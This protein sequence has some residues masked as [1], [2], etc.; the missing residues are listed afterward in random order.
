MGPAGARSSAD[1]A[2][3]YPAAKIRPAVHDGQW[4]SFA[5]SGGSG[6]S[7]EGRGS[8]T[9]ARNTA[10]SEAGFRSFGS[11]NG[12]FRGGPGFAGRGYYGWGGGVW[13]G[14]G[15]GWGRGWGWGFGI[16]WA[17]CGVCWDP[18]LY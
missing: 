17:C 6:R 7:G 9:V 8:G 5:G 3:A 11:T 1:R 2:G 14:G 18:L 13:W 4:H 15:F 10:G 12:A 16:G